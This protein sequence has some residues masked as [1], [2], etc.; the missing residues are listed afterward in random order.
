MSI[1]QN[2]RYETLYA[3]ELAELWAFIMPGS[4][5]FA[6]DPLLT[7][8]MNLSQVIKL[9]NEFPWVIRKKQ[10]TQSILAHF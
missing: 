4:A 3:A 10:K 2:G 9:K 1:E 6:F 8:V 7:H 5:D